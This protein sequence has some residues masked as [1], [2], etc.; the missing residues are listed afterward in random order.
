MWRDIHNERMHAPCGPSYLAALLLG[1]HERPHSLQ[2]PHRHIPVQQKH[3]VNLACHRAPLRLCE[4]EGSDSA[5][6]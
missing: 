3:V 4:I 2:I 1:H 5:M 6:Q